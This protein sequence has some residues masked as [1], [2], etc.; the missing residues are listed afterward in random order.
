MWRA[1]FETCTDS[2]A[3]MNKRPT[4]REQIDACRPD[5]DDLHLPQHAADL[6][7]LAE[8]VR[9][10]AELRTRWEQSQQD[11]RLI[12][13]AMHDVTIPVGLEQRLLAAVAQASA[14]P[15]A[16]AV[17]EANDTRP[18]EQPAVTV[19]AAER[20][21][22]QPSLRTTRR[23]FPRIAI[24]LC[25]VAALMLL[26]ISGRQFWKQDSQPVNKN[27]LAARV[28]SWLQTSYDPGMQ[29]QRTS[30][31]LDG[32]PQDK[33]LGQIA[34]WSKLR[35]PEEP[36][37]VAYDLTIG[38]NQ[39]RLLV[40]STS[41]QYPV[42]ALPWTPIGVSGGMTVGAWQKGDVLY[43]LAVRDDSRLHQFVRPQ[44][45]G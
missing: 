29:W 34:R 7:E 13:G 44:T 24:A 22:D 16:A 25:G 6:A 42:A 5:S 2:Q 1:S 28:E 30:A 26:A 10:S 40:V 23:S 4:L 21:K 9:T 19:A 15:L 8:G 17:A 32:F 18:P 45:I 20:A 33:V 11:D 35:S 12:R 39:A 31:P 38:G 27:E 41:Q 36:N 37:I 3:N 14:A 43:V